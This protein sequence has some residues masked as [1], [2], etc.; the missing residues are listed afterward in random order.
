MTESA[1][2]A[3]GRKRK[4]RIPV[5]EV[6]VMGELLRRGFAAQLTSAKPCILLVQIGDAQPKP[7]Q[8]KTVHGPPWYL[9]R[10]SFRR[11]RA[12]Q[13]TIF[14]LLRSEHGTHSAR[15]F[16][17]TRTDLAALFR[18]SPAEQA[19]VSIDAKSLEQYENKWS[20]LR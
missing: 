7:V 13:V 2:K 11:L 16:V 10:S 9:R 20:V 15:F 18:E 8:V 5:G 14:V 6:F 12:D 3:I 4:S 19:F 17:T 1:G